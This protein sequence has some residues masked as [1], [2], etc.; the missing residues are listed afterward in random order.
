MAGISPLSSSLSSVNCVSSA[1]KPLIVGLAGYGTVGAGLHEALV[2][3]KASIVQRTGRDILI[4]TVAVRDPAKARDVPFPPGAKVT[5]AL[6]TLWQDPETDVVVEL[7]GGIDR[8]EKLIVH[9]LDAGKDVVTANKA[10]LAEKG[11]A[12]FALAAANNRRL[13]YEASV[14]GA[15]P[16]VGTFKYALAGNRFNELVGI[17]NG[18][19]NYILSQMTTKNLT[20]AQAL[21]EAQELGYAEA[22]PTLDI[23]G[24]DTAHKL[25]LLVRLAFGATY[26]FHLL[27][28][29][30][31]SGIQPMDIEF[32]REFGYRIKLL[33]VARD[34]EG[35]LE[36][37]VFPALVPHTLL[38]ARVGGAY[39]A[40]RADGNCS[41]PIFLHGLGAGA[42]PTGSAVLSDIMAVARGLSPD[43]TGF[44]CGTLPPANVMPPEDAVSRYYLRCMVPDTPGVLRDLAGA[45]AEY[46][47]SV[48]QAI[49]KSDTPGQAVPIVFMTHQARASAMRSALARME[50]KNLLAEE[51]VYYNVL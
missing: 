6:E 34:R 46:G 38:L 13:G 44:S 11:D 33:G 17:L 15:I 51:P 47:I 40:V 2:T 42:L 43:N 10:L 35:R 29:R 21:K 25:T 28:V 45:M 22:D 30:G 49:Q 41:G 12:L 5:T 1:K 16:V 31:I 8:A 37:G 32:A 24:I 26:P 39:N 19:S 20:F 14:C 3:N 48:A 27:P 4:K 9:A 36:A 18:T 50:T 23:E 7:I